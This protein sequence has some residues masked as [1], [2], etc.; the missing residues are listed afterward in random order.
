MTKVVT[1]ITTQRFDKYDVHF[2]AEWD[3]TYVKEPYTDDELIAA[4]KDAEILF[5]GSVHTVSKAV[6][7]ACP[8]LKFIQTEGV[9]FDKVDIAAAKEAGI[10]V[11]NNRGVN[12]GAVA[13]HTIAL[14]LA[15]FRRIA[16]SDRQYR[17]D[18]F[19]VSKKDHFAKGQHEISGK[20]IGFV[21]MGAIAKE[22]VKRLAPWG[23]KFIYF[24]VFRP[25]PEAEKELNLEY[26][27][28]N[29]LVKTADVISIHVPVLPSTE[30]MFGEAQFKAMKKTALVV[31]TARGEVINQDALA[32]A[33][34]EGEIYGAALDVLYPEPAPSDSLILNMG[35]EAM[36]RITFTPHIGGTTDEAFTTMLIRGMENITRVINGEEPVNIV[37]N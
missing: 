14:I 20:V 27:E 18:G 13:E 1:T 25:S 8:K 36:D 10:P 31:N 35:R 9:G 16:L 29:E 15:G 32:K 30:G 11:S 2:P 19:E 23:C 4:A 3:V 28:F 6:I 26:M 24:D 22:T 17:R 5:V 12:A 34:E 21:G 7:A 37:N 33:I